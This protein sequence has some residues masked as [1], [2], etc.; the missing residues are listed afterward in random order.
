MISKRTVVAVPVRPMNL[1]SVTYIQSHIL[2]IVPLG[3]SRC[4][5]QRVTPLLTSTIT[6]TGSVTDVPGTLHFG[7][8]DST[9]KRSDDSLERSRMNDMV[10]FDGSGQSSCCNMSSENKFSVFEV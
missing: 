10:T 7:S 3:V 9:S 6:H 5:P 1:G 2:A 8:D 4:H